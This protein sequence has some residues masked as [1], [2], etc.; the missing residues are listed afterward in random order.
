MSFSQLVNQAQDAKAAYLHIVSG[1]KPCI[2]TRQGIRTLGN[3][4]LMPSDV[5]QLV[6]ECL[7]P[8]MKK[9]LLKG[10]EV[11]LC[12]NHDGDI[13]LRL[14]VYKQRGTLAISAKL[15]DAEILSFNQLGIEESLYDSMMSQKT[16][17]FLTSSERDSG[18]STLALSFLQEVARNRSVHIVSIEEVIERRFDENIKGLI[19]RCQA[20]VDA[21]NTRTSLE[22]FC[23]T[24]IQVCFLD[25]LDDPEYFWH[26]LELASRGILVVGTL[27]AK[28]IETLLHKI[29]NIRS[30]QGDYRYKLA[31]V[32]GHVVHQ[33]CL[34]T[35]DGGPKF[36][37][38]HFL[39]QVATRNHIRENKL[40]PILAYMRTV[41]NKGCKSYQQSY[42]NLVADELLRADDIPQKYQTNND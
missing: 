6:D 4:I 3:S 18:R 37:R 11:L 9:K 7:Q 14:H 32:L 12:Y 40:Q 31:D 10:E 28:D 39:N 21:L 26:A 19:S 29:L 5:Y 27:I 17:L 41:G 8:E 42:S 35:E 1:T 23:K 25:S 2:K 24:D 20:G 22:G 36:I 38:E 13:E 16:G 34:Q 30:L 15:I 33:T